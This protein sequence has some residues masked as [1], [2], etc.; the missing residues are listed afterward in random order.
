MYFV[1]VKTPAQSTGAWDY[2]NVLATIPGDQ[3]FLPLEE[4]GCPLVKQR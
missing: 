3:A 4:G 1:E 2:Y